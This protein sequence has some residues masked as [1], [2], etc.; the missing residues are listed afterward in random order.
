MS[1]ISFYTWTV[2]TCPQVCSESL[3]SA[4]ASLFVLLGQSLVVCPALWMTFT[5]ASTGIVPWISDAPSSKH[6]D[7]VS[8]SRHSCKGALVVTQ[9]PQTRPLALQLAFK[10]HKV[11]G[12]PEKIKPRA[13]LTHQHN[14]PP[15]R[16]GMPHL[17]CRHACTDLSLC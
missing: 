17:M 10:Q 16:Q 8:V 7:L 9:R 14:G 5:L 3:G 4:D 6:T 12:Q 15:R 2:V 1:V 13:S 11:W